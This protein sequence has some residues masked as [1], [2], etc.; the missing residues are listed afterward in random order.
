MHKAHCSIKEKKK[1]DLKGCRKPSTLCRYRWGLSYDRC[2]PAQNWRMHKKHAQHAQKTKLHRS[3][4]FNHWKHLSYVLFVAAPEPLF[5][6]DTAQ[7]ISPWWGLWFR[8][9]KWEAMRCSA[10]VFKQNP[11]RQTASPVPPAVSAHQR[12]QETI[13]FFISGLL[14]CRERGWYEN[15]AGC[16]TR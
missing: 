6:T 1:R 12:S 16:P 11:G 7:D 2:W 3:G 5:S 14:G 8:L 4:E 10:E 13:A 9:S 15:A